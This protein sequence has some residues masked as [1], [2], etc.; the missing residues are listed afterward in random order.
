M[1]GLPCGLSKT[2]VE[3]HLATAVNASSTLSPVL[4]DV[5]M[6]GTLCSRPRRSPSSRFTC[7]S[8]LLQSAL[9]PFKVE[10]I[11]TETETEKEKV[12]MRL[13][14]DKKLQSFHS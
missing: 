4:A 5:S 14:S 8:L 7:R 13:K 2:F 9:L 1:L 11:E 3:P 12:Q 10:E 6:N